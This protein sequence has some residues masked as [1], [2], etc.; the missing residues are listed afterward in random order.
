MERKGEPEEKKFLSPT[1]RTAGWLKPDGPFFQALQIVKDYVNG[2]QDRSGVLPK[3]LLQK[4]P[5][6]WMDYLNRL[7]FT[8]FIQKN[9]RHRDI[10]ILFPDNMD[11]K[12]RTTE[13]KLTYQADSGMF[14]VTFDFRNNFLA[15]GFPDVMMLDFDFDKDQ[16]KVLGQA[17]AKQTLQR[18]SEITRIPWALYE[19][20]RGMHAFLVSHRAD[21]TD[22]KWIHLMLLAKADPWYA[23]FAT[24]FG[25]QIRLNAKESSPDDFVSRPLVDPNEEKKASADQHDNNIFFTNPN[26][27]EQAQAAID[28][29]L[30]N[31]VLFHMELIR[32]AVQ[33][34]KYGPEG[35]IEQLKCD[36]GNVVLD[37]D[38][39]YILEW[40][41]NIKAA[42]KKNG[43]ILT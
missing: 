12:Y 32:M 23:A 4:Q 1:D 9:V 2:T 20:D 35:T 22:M 43:I 19:T 5:T 31:R 16:D 34:L 25:W 39:P 11:G 37:K 28:P 36:V 18:L 42:A 7:S 3:E 33:Q 24:V 14:C 38:A 10:F 40:R 21:Y 17:G 8:I 29:Y 27:K 26:Q 6:C 13:H 15:L 30:K 41:K